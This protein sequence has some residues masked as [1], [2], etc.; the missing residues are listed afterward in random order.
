MKS[1]Y[2]SE[3]GRN[4]ILALYDQKLKSLNIDYQTILIETS[5]GHTNIIATGDPSAPPLV[6]VHGSNGCAPISLETYP[7]LSKSY[8]VFAVDVPAQPNKSAET[9]MSMKNDDYGIWM[10]EVMQSLEI[11]NVT[12]V[13]FSLGGLVILKALEYDESRIKEVFLAAPAYIANGNP[14]KALLKIFIPLRVYMYTTKTKY[15]ERFL[16]V[17]FTN[18]D[19][20][21]FQFLSKVLLHF[22]LD[23]SPVPVIS[24]TKARSIQTP[25]TLFAAKKDV[26]FPGEKMIKRAIEI[27]SSLKETILLEDSKHVQNRSHND[28]IEKTILESISSLVA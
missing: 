14:L 1:L 24:K 23:F 5:F 11:E 17:L 7:N 21:A 9:R 15:V 26:L 27:F 28:Q 19:E 4:E 8:R 18:R 2:K 12:M 6:I 22:I 10:N 16:D 25:I 13:G 3:T 20:F